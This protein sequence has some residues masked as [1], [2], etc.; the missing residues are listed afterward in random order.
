MN[1]Y[2]VLLRG[3][4]VGGRIIKMADLRT[5]FEKAGYQKVA[6]VLQTGNVLLS[7][8][9]SADRLQPAIEALLQ[10]SFH[11]P[12][13]VLVLNSSKLQEV[14]DAYPFKNS[15]EDYHR[16]VIFAELG[17]EKHLTLDAAGLDEDIESVQAAKDV[18]YWRVQKGHTLDSAFGNQ[19]AKLSSKLFVTNR[20]INTLQKILQKAS[21]LS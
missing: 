7:S 17:F 14:V 15:N 1:R 3:I 5:C 9:Q 18:L 10:K 19:L 13:R 2:V 21:E 16:Y 6:T 11:Y 20:N 4:N 8:D 12:A